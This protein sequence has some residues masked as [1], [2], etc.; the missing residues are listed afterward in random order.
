MKIVEFE[1]IKDNREMF[2][3]SFTLQYT[4]MIILH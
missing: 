3:K 2:H 1:E 4:T